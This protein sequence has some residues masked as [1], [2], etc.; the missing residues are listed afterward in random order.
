MNMM[1]RPAGPRPYADRAGTP[2]LS[3][4]LSLALEQDGRLIVVRGEGLW[5][6]AQME[7]HLRDYREMLYRQ[8]LIFSRVRVLVDLKDMSVQ[9]PEVADLLS[10]VTRSFHQDGDRIAMIVPS[11]LAKMQMRRVLETRFHEY[12][13]STNAARNWL[14]GG[15]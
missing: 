1:T 11:S 6:M 14:A 4:E 13:M 8:R 5:T 7:E 10:Q 15:A 3:G 2:P 12:F 9:R